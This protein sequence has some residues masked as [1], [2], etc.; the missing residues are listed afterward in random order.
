MSCSVNVQQIIGPL[1]TLVIERQEDAG[2]PGSITTTNIIITNDFLQQI[3]V[4]D[5]CRGTQ[6]PSGPPGPEGPAGPSG[7]P[8]PTFDILPIVSGGTNNNSF[9]ADY[10][11]YYDGA[12]DQLAS[13]N[14]TIN[15]II[16]G[17]QALT[18]IVE[19]SGIQKTDL[20]NN[21][22]RLDAIVGDGLDVHRTTNAIF[23]DGTIARL[24][25][26]TPGQFQGVLPISKG[27]TANTSYL[28]G[29]L[30][31]F[32]SSALNGS[33]QFISAGNLNADEIVVSGNGFTLTAGSGLVNGGFVIIPNGTGRI[34]IPESADITVFADSFEL[35]PTGTAG[36][37]TKVTTDSKGRVESGGQLTPSDIYNIL[38]YIPWHPGNDGCGSE[39]DADL[40]CGQSGDYYLNATNITGI[41][42]TGVLP[43]I[44]IDGRYTKVDVNTKGLVTS[45]MQ[46]T[47][48]D[49]ED[50]LG[51]DPVRPTGG[52]DFCGDIELHGSLFINKP[53][54]CPGATSGLLRVYDN[55]PLIARNNAD[56]GIDEPRGVSFVYGGGFISRTGSIAYYPTEDVVYVT[57]NMM[58]NNN[59]VDG[60]DSDDDFTDDIN[61]G[62]ANSAFPISNLTGTKRLLLYKDTAD[63]L[64]VSLTKDQQIVAGFKKWINGIGVNDQ[65]I[66]YDNDGNPTVPPTNVGS[67]TLLNVNFNADLLDGQH[68]DYYLDAGNV[69]GIFD[70]SKVSFG[71]IEGTKNYIPKFDGNNNP[72]NI[73]RDSVMY[74]DGVTRDITIGEEKNLIVGADQD[75]LQSTSTRN[76]LIGENNGVSAADNSLLVGQG[77][78]VHDAKNVI[79]AGLNASG[80]KDNS[81]A[82]GRYGT[83]WLQNQIAHG[84]YRV[85][86]SNGV[87]IEHGQASDY[88]MYLEGQT[89]V[90]WVNLV[91]PVQLPDDTTLAFKVSLLMNSAFSTG[92]AEFEFYSGIVKNVKLRDPQDISQIINVTTVMQ[93]PMKNEIYNNSHIHDYYLQLLCTDL[94]EIQNETIKVN[95]PPIDLLPIRIDNEPTEIIGKYEDPD[96]YNATYLKDNLG[97]MAITLDPA[98]ITGNY[99]GTAQGDLRVTCN[100]HGLLAGE[101]TYI[102]FTSHEQVAFPDDRYLVKAVID[103]NTFVLQG[104]HWRAEKQTDNSLKLCSQY[105]LMISED[106]M[107][108]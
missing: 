38:G 92:V 46:M 31:T 84:A 52:V 22:I 60:G 49:I 101:Y 32:D 99:V 94:N 36:T 96:G 83:A 90:N 29:K 7:L 5:V 15:D 86:D 20:P 65:V 88:M 4:V 68:G 61:G 89:A 64:Y 67:N 48:Q 9:N 106:L 103:E 8:G 97:N 72:A 69:T 91:P 19:G 93:Q 80:L 2:D 30:I 73:I 23:V 12:S 63:E 10:I 74:E 6:G 3:E 27:G 13:S 33:G 35:S 104:L 1:N 50:I 81:I 44:M 71:F 54:G 105:F 66:I 75:N 79:A 95:D 76:A 28:D 17:A 18:G 70:P 45:G 62:D 100:D 51:Y 21:Q 39:L 37:Y 85:D 108:R 78:Q 87:L 82:H 24:D 77:N 58:T 102:E 43:D 42:N 47:P 55:M 25:D 56:I 107:S 26:L 57:T 53:T 14:Y 98:S 41:I 59:G 16:A 40:L 11:I 34:D